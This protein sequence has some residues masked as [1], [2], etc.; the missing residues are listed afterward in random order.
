MR[1]TI[2]DLHRNTGGWV[3][4]AAQGEDLVITDRGRPVAS[5]VQFEEAYTALPF[6]V[7]QVLP[8][9]HALP[10]ASGDATAYVSEDRERR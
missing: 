5:L 10:E 2:R 4:R 3:H 6:R 1:I 7:R 9:F 8:E